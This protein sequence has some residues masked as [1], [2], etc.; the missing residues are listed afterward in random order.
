MKM[1]SVLR[2]ALEEMFS[3]VQR[4]HTSTA[5]PVFCS[6][7]RYEA[8]GTGGLKVTVK[9]YYYYK[10]YTNVNNEKLC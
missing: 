2:L 8:A 1:L 10:M 6:A 3:Q 7:R 9:N 5:S 4:R